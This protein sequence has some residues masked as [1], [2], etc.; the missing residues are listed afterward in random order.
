MQRKLSENIRRILAVIM[1]I[2]LTVYLFGCGQVQFGIEGAA[3]KQQGFI[4]QLELGKKYLAEGKYEEAVVAFNKVIELNEKEIQ[5]YTGLIQAYQR[6][7]DAER[8]ETAIQQGISVQ[9]ENS[10]EMSTD[11]RLDFLLTAK[12][13]YSEKGNL[14]KSIELL[15]TLTKIQPD[16]AEFSMELLDT[17]LQLDNSEQS[18]GKI[19]ELIENNPQALFTE[20][21]CEP[22]EL[23]I[24]DIPFWEADFEDAMAQYPCDDLQ[25]M[26]IHD[27]GL[28]RTYAVFHNVSEKQA[29]ATTIFRIDNSNT[30]HEVYFGTYVQQMKSKDGHQID[31]TFRKAIVDQPKLRG[32]R[33]GES[34]DEMIEKLGFSYMADIY[35][36]RNNSYGSV[37]FEYFENRGWS[38]YTRK[39]SQW[40]ETVAEAN[41]I[42]IRWE[43]GEKVV[44]VDFIFDGSDILQEVHYD[45]FDM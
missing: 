38:F 7:G 5:A 31:S 42:T 9:S 27:S 37:T 26:E 44:A 40:A 1:G 35:L 15:E 39:D 32:I 13:Y 36:E 8:I 43:H 23:T 33:I 19:T 3:G 21:F 30:R 2:F 45:A 28:A 20:D 22:E 4:E 11:D 17:Y 10:Y 12:S 25:D 24:N 41:S 34:K 14:E 16:N 18:F 29:N 6:T